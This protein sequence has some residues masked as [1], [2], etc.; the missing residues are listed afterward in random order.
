MMKAFNFQMCVRNIARFADAV[1]P[2]GKHVNKPIK[3]STKACKGIVHIL[4]HPNLGDSG[5]PLRGPI[6]LVSTDEHLPGDHLLPSSAFSRGG[7]VCD[8]GQLKTKQAHIMIM[9]KSR[10]TQTKKSM[11]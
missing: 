1:Q 7:A 2:Q 9:F 8:T 6:P 5:A 3:K 11:M 10:S 4:R